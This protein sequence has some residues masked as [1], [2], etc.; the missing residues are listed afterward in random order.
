[1]GRSL[2]NSRPVFDDGDEV[3]VEGEDGLPA[4]IVVADHSGAFTEYEVP[5]ESF[6]P[7][8]ARPVNR[9]EA[10]VPD[11]YHFANL[12][13]QALRDQLLHIQ[14]DYRVRRRAFQN[15]FTQRKYDPAGSFA[16]RWECVLRRSDQCDPEHVVERFAAMCGC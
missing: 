12:Y 6:A 8:Y 11:A 9:R 16:Y 7:D 5:L 3:V 2:E 4:Q 1:M 14:N 13:L 15:L 10:W